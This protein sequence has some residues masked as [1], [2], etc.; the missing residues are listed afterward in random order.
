MRLPPRAG[1]VLSRAVALFLGVLFGFFVAFNA[2]FSDVFGVGEM[3]GAIAYVLVAYFV[4]GFV[5]GL[6]APETGW[7]WTP[8]LAAPGVLFAAFMIFDNPARVLYVGGVMLSAAAATFAGSWLG[9]FARR[10]RVSSRRA[11]SPRR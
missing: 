11:G 6:A 10:S 2:V 5:Y 8:W 4:L 1:L 7:R 3:L 9:A